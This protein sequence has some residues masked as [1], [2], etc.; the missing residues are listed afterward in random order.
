MQD[1]NLITSTP[2][3]PIIPQKN[4][5]K[6]VLLGFSILAFIALGYLTYNRIST[7]DKV[8]SGRPVGQL[9]DSYKYEKTDR[10][11]LSINDTNSKL[12]FSK[13]VEMIKFSEVKDSTSS[14]ASLVHKNKGGFSIANI[15]ATIFNSKLVEDKVF[16]TALNEQMNK[17]QGKEYDNVVVPVIKFAKDSTAQGYKIN[18]NKPKPYNANGIKSNAWR[19]NV[20]AA[21]D[22]QKLAPIKGVIV[23]AI[24]GQTTYY[25]G[26]FSLEYNWEPNIKVWE[27]SINSLKL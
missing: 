17:G 19:F 4:K 18:L 11:E 5:K 22:E 15:G 16:L 1:P 23:M 13:P 6:Y 27:Q 10:Y 9:P 7:P 20:S 14:A 21:D 24:K 25:W 26:A 3:P 2:T 8:L 12:S